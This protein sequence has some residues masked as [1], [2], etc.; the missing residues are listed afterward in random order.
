[1][2][3]VYMHGIG[4]GDPK[5]GWLDGLNRGLVQA[6]HPSVD[7]DRVIAPRYRSLLN[8][9]GISAK[10]PPVTYKPKD[11]ASGR[12]GFERR[13]A[14]VQ[15][16]LV[17]EPGVRSFGFNRIP[18][19]PLSV[20]QQAAINAIPWYD[21][22]QVKRYMQSEATRGAI[23]QHIL[24]YLPTSGD[25]LLIG[26]SLGSVIAIDLL[27]NLHDGLHV[28]RFVTIGS[29][30][31]SRPLHENS[32]RL[33]KK[34]PYERVD[35]W[36][37]FFDV[38]DVVTGGRGLASTFPGAQ[39]FAIDI[40][41]Q[42]GADTY[43]GNASIS[44]V[45]A[46]VLYPTKTVALRES[47]IAVR[48]GDSEAT[49]LLSLHFGRAVQRHIKD[50]NS[51]ARYADALGAQQDEVVTQIESAAMASNIAIAPELFE[52]AQ[53]TLPRL[54]HR[55]EL[56]EAVSELVVLAMTNL[57]EPYEINVDRA[58]KDA[59]ADMTV[60]LGFQ[61]STGTKIGVAIEDVQNYV[62]RKGGVPWGRVLTAAAGVAIVAAGPVGL[63]VAAPAGV[64]G[65]AALT[66]GL[67]ALGP[68]GM[69]GGL[70]MLG[71][72]AGT[73]AAVATT[74]ATASGGAAQPVSDSNTLVL[75]VAVE[76]ARKRLDL[77]YDETLWYQIT[78]LETQLSARINR[79]SVYSDPK[80]SA[81][82]TLRVGQYTV[83]RLLAFML[84]KGLG[85]KALVAAESETD[86]LLEEEARA[87]ETSAER[88]RSS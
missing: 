30:A 3:I 58:P 22:P 80:S 9:S 85:P 59:L 47:G 77:P 49:V 72:L 60:E 44:G 42:H 4:D 39:D 78:D 33:L 41:G 11:D 6:G 20:L 68:G 62:S 5:M 34:F 84:D 88:Q 15:R 18:E 43:L 56:H 53:G 65:A 26:H 14:K 37:N 40:G 86:R 1:M 61:R 50:K 29:P 24:D 73:G 45:I 66:G 83:T 10:I 12:R 55:W 70:A 71:G 79:L 48:L 13:Q 36:T 75:R 63:L 57:I 51:A 25:I 31:S 27:D 7:P 17:L 28:R 46:D 87:I 74:A 2:R 38:R 81:L 35:D 76:H 21:L 32:D 69:V 54:P 16:K 23:L 19:G 52:L 67:A 82:E 64:F 8:T